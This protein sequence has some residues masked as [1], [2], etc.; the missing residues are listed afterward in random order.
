MVRLVV[1]TFSTLRAC[2]P[3]ECISFLANT[4]FGVFVFLGLPSRKDCD[5][6]SPHDSGRVGT[7]SVDP[8]LRV[9][10]QVVKTESNDVFVEVA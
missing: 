10:T 7:R 5:S 6:V 9:Q 2:L 3:A 1:D 4:L 8:G